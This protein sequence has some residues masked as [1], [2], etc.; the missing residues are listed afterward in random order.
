[1]PAVATGFAESI[2]AAGLTTPTAMAPVPDG[3]IFV[4][5]K[6][7][8]LRVVANG[9]VLPT[10]FAAIPVNAFSER[11]LVGVAVDPNFATN[12]F[13]Y[14]YY[15]TEMS[16]PNVTTV[17]NRVSRFTASG[18]V[19]APGSELVL[20][21]DIPSTNGTGVGSSHMKVFTG[22]T[23]QELQSFL[24]FDSFFGGVTVGYAGSDVMS[25]PRPRPRTSRRSTR[26]GRRRGASSR[27]TASPAECG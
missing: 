24:A 15:T 12:H 23:G 11:G 20:L 21:D 6:T 18:N 8:A 13:V 27:S 9:T 16:T 17:V 10:P 4:A 26:P 1:M 25:S 5:E 3:R 14:A 2:F 22:R 19:V 7:G